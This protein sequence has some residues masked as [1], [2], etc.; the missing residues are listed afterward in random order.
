MKT[1]SVTK[2]WTPTP[3]WTW[4][5]LELPTGCVW[6]GANR[7]AHASTLS[8][9]KTGL[10]AADSALYLHGNLFLVY[11]RINTIH[12]IKGLSGL[13]TGVILLGGL[14]YGFGAKTKMLVEHDRAAE[15]HEETTEGWRE[16]AGAA[17]CAGEA[18]VLIYSSSRSFSMGGTEAQVDIDRALRVGQGKAEQQWK[19]TENSLHV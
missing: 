19:V 4:K 15:T 7:G 11:R 6:L 12:I 3:A 10:G 16:Q 8:D 9:G 17:G 1:C 14:E 2:S 18:G 13:Q 5:W